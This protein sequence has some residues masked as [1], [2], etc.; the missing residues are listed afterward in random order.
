M[1]TLFLN[2]FFGGKLKAMA[3]KLQS[4]DGRHVVIRPLAYVSEREIDR[5]AR[6]RAFPIIPCNLCGSQ[7][8]LQRA[9]IK[10][11]LADWEKAYPVA[12]SRSSPPCAMSSRRI[13]PTRGFLISCAAWRGMKRP[14]ANSYWVA[15]GRCSPASILRVIR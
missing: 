8:N 14:L 11:M 1:E 10:Q 7:E 13:W 9:S 4:E 12:P 2:L 5:Y 3:P 6:A 15:P